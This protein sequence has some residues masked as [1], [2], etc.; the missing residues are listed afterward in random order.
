[1]LCQLK[2]KKNIDIFLNINK[3]A[4]YKT[5][6][7]CVSSQR[8]EHAAKATSFSTSSNMLSG[9]SSRGVRRHH[10]GKFG[11]NDTC[12]MLNQ[13]SHSMAAL[14]LP[15]ARA[16]RLAQGLLIPTRLPENRA[17]T[18]CSASHFLANDFGRNALSFLATMSFSSTRAPTRRRHERNNQPAN[19]TEQHL[20]PTQAGEAPCRA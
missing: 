20:V 17:T 6:S 4:S 1:M 8:G 18:S 3:C 10:D 14:P 19:T 12:P 2:P 5:R 11:E 9:T 15:D 13:K 16:S 7:R